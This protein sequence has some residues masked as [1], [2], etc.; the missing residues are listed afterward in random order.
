M[1]HNANSELSMNHW[2]KKY[3]NRSSLAWRKKLA[4]RENRRN[5]KF[6]IAE[7]LDDC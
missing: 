4:H 7:E 6:I 1:K 5:E 3:S 2:H